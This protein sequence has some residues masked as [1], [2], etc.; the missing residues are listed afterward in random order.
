MVEHEAV[1]VDQLLASLRRHGHVARGA[2]NHRHLGAL[3]LPRRRRL[4]PAAERD[5][6]LRR[7]RRRR[8]HLRVLP[9]HLRRRRLP[10]PT[11]S[12]KHLAVP[13]HQ[14]LLLAKP[15]HHRA[16]GAADDNLAGGGAET[17]LPR[18]EHGFS[19]LDRWW[20]A[21]QVVRV[22]GHGDRDEHACGARL[23]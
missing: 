10:H 7:V 12:N 8:A 16:T 2:K 6:A 9:H 20:E 4:L 15:R 13:L 22:D 18:R 14:L 17:R 1:D 23:I 21:V 5:A 3:P 19:R 11:T